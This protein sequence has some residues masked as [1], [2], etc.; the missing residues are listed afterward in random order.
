MQTRSLF[1]LHPD[2]LKIV[3][4]GAEALNE[5]Q[6]SIIYLHNQYLTILDQEPITSS[7]QHHQL[8]QNSYHA[9]IVYQLSPPVSRLKGNRIFS[10]CLQ[11]AL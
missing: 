11:R 5:Q 8:L 1:Y 3:S 4:E 2:I 10:S 9:S 6:L 7:S